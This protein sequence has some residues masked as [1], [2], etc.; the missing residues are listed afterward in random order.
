MTSEQSAGG[1]DRKLVE[2]KVRQVIYGGGVYDAAEV[3]DES[4]YRVAK[5][6]F[7]DHIR[8]DGDDEVRD[9]AQTA[10][11]QIERSVD[12]ETDRDEGVSS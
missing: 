11:D 1:T 6:M 4:E 10:I 2:Q 3:F 9:R 5:R 8:P 12:T 7:S